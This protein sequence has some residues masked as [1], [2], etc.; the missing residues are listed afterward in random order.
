MM[1]RKFK[2]LFLL[3]FI[4][5]AALMAVELMGAKLVAPF[6][7]SSLYVWT[8]VLVSTVLGLTLGYYLGG[9]VSQKRNTEKKL[10]IILGI[11]AILV[12]A[13]PHTASM[14]IQLTR[15][16]SL[17]PGVCVTCLALLLPPLLCFGM[18]GPIAV[19]LMSS[20]AETLG[21]T[22]GTVYFTS[23][24]GG[25]VATFLFGYYLVPLEGLKFC[26]LVTGVSLAALPIAYFASRAFH[27]KAPR[28]KYPVDNSQIA[29]DKAVKEKTAV[30]KRHSVKP[31]IY[32]FAVLE[33]G[34]VMATELIAARMMAPYFGAS[35]FVWAAVIGFTLCGLAIGYFAG[36]KMADKYD[37]L[38]TMR[39]TLLV[40]SV[41]LLLMH[42]TSQ[43]LTIALKGTDINFAVIIVGF[44][45][46]VPPLTALGM[47]PALLI[48]HITDKAENAGAMAG[49]VYALSSAS[50][51]AALILF[52]FFIIPVYGLTGP[53]IITG[54]IIGALPFIQLIS[55]KKYL[56]LGL[57]F[58]I[59]LSVSFKKTIQPST[60][61][62]VQYYSEGLLGQV[63]VADMLNNTN[64]T[65]TTSRVLYVN[66]IGETFINKTTGGTEA[67]YLVYVSCVA[68]KLKEHSDALL[69]GLGGGTIANMLHNDLKYNVD[70]AELD[71]RITDVS[72][73]YFSLNDSVH[74]TVDDARHY[75]EQTNKKYDLIFFDVFRG[76]IPPPHVLSLESFK[77]AKSLLNEN[78]MIVVNFFGFLNG[79]IGEAGRSIYKTL[80]AAGLHARI[81]PTPGPEEERNL[82]FIAG[83]E[84]EDFSK[85]RTPLYLYGKL[86]DVDTM[87]VEHK[88]PGLNDAVILTDDKPILD[89]VV[90]S[91]TD[92]FR[93]Y[94][95]R[96][97]VKLFWDNGVPLFK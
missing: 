49:R 81:L 26:T 71:Q 60:D 24:A 7:G 67:N 19:R 14:L 31:G 20:S 34:A 27:A 16:L 15:S 93:G 88:T 96:S 83:N 76:D 80:C 75:L 86:V 97:D 53:S 72:R 29:E 62:D 64:G 13:L 42:I 43:Q 12:F 65:M 8:T 58:F 79:D 38:I 48:R 57:L 6:Y 47:V 37:P 17:I 3:L 39:W 25:V 1:F 30:V 41:L 59:L 56:S 28:R 66:R 11:A 68:S 70:V 63:L 74:V 87:F 5:G 50:G 54:I 4:E 35:L 10:A 23:T 55:Q 52:G 21:T 51:I 85:L 84:N 18:V 69:L 36:G 92:N 44:L 61:I 77:R 91:A 40:A 2:F 46:V 89:L 32:L 95:D 73:E 90:L 82:L 9:I 22:A 78:G 94:Y 33:G 45:V